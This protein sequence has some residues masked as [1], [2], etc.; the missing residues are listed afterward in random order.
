MASKS[1]NLNK[2]YCEP[3]GLCNLQQLQVDFDQTLY[4]VTTLHKR[5]EKKTLGTGKN[6][7]LRP[8]IITE[9]QNS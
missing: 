3:Q 6:P 2:A 8:V 4:G 1:N 9:T 7:A 5:S